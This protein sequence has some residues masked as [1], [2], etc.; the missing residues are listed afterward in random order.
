MMPPAVLGHPVYPQGHIQDDVDHCP[1]S[2]NP[3]NG[4]SE[5]MTIMMT[6]VVVIGI[7]VVRIVRIVLWGDRR[8][9]IIIFDSLGGWGLDT[10]ILLGW[11]VGAHPCARRR[12][13][14]FPLC[15][16]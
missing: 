9:R 10:H 5:S 8:E 2:C 16:R 12:A 3:F 15:R 7:P 13:I 6:L 11:W 1:F 14:C 4:V